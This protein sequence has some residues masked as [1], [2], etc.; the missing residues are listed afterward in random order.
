MI[1]TKNYTKEE[2]NLIYYLNKPIANINDT[3]INSIINKMLNNKDFEELIYF[4]NKLYDFAKIPKNIV[5]RLINENNK[6]CI[7]IF[8]ENE[9]SLYFFSD[10]EKNILKKFLNVY[11]VNIK[12]S[13]TFDY[14]Y[15]LLFDQGFR[16]F[17][18]IKINDKI[19]EHLFTRDSKFTKIKL[20]EIENIG[21]IV[22]YINYTY[23]NLSKEEQRLKEI[24]YIN[25]FG[26]NIN[27]NTHNDFLA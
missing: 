8:L 12:L 6:E 9:D 2:K 3:L 22:S 10:K 5:E 7:S 21:V 13:N 16:N 25:K 11:E 15:K 17:K 4:L 18:T 26:F 1:I 23:F 27:R 14:Y 19:I 20:K 24:D